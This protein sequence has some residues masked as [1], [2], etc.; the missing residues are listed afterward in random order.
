MSGKE[1]KITENERKIG[2]IR[3]H[4]VGKTAEWACAMKMGYHA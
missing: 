1:R 4:V 2:G 3:K